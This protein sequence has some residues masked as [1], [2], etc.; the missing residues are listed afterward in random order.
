MT[1]SSILAPARKARTA[2]C[3]E[4]SE[5]KDCRPQPGEANSWREIGA[6]RRAVRA[7]M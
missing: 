7:A 5:T 1:K 4:H 6:R 2:R 3:S